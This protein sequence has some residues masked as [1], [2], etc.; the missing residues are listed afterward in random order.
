MSLIQTI[1]QYLL[2]NKQAPKT[3]HQFLNWN[4]VKSIFIIAYDNQLADVVDFV[5]TCK[6]SHIS[7]LVG[8]VYDGKPESSPNPAFEHQLLTKKE[9]NWFYIPNDEVVNELNIKQFDVLI[10]VSSVQQLKAKAL[11]KLISASCKIGKYE[12]VIFD[13]SIVTQK[14][15][16]EFLTEVHKYLNMIK[17]I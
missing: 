5:N 6:Q 11:S 14:N 1:S 4:D 2:A 17:T 13:V 9:F 8:V 16:S 10:N 7:V 15:N 3:T 12:D